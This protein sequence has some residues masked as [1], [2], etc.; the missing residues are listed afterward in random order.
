MHRL[1]CK[2]RD[3]DQCKIIRHEEGELEEDLVEVG[4]HSPE[5]FAPAKRS[6]KKWKKSV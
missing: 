2:I 4:A 1:C 3:T 6:I 5:L